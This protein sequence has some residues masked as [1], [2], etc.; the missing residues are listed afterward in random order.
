MAKFQMWQG[1]AETLNFSLQRESERREETKRQT[2][3]SRVLKCDKNKRE[4]AQHKWLN[5]F[6]THRL[7]DGTVT[8]M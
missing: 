5:I 3:D 7:C 4:M 6:H 8:T 2:S 1:P